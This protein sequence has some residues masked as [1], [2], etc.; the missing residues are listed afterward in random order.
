M[1]TKERDSSDG[2]VGRRGEH[3]REQKVIVIAKWVAADDEGWW[4]T[5]E[6]EGVES[7]WVWHKHLPFVTHQ[8]RRDGGAS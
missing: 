6:Y 5:V 1:K 2:G 4:H 3:E 8:P 7:E